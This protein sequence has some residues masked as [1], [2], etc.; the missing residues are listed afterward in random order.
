MI[1]NK[2]GKQLAD[3]AQFCDGCGAQI[4]QS[5]DDQNGARNST[6]NDEQQNKVIFMLAYLGI[7]FFLPL[8]ATPDSKAGRF[9]ANQGLVL[10]I[11]GVAGQIVFSVLSAV[12]WRLWILTSLLSTVW[13][14][15]LFVFMIMGMVNAYNGVQKQLPVIGGIKILK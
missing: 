10:L 3:D 4:S 15:G 11:T 5:K 13:G 2:C 7:L 8:V 14:I 9:H 6:Q 12:A 1:C